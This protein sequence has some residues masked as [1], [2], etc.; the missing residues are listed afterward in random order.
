M[1]SCQTSFDLLKCDNGQIFMSHYNTC[2][3]K[4]W[5]ANLHFAIVAP[6]KCLTLK[7]IFMQAICHKHPFH[8]SWVRASWAELLTET[9]HISP[10]W[11]P[12]C[13]SCG[14][15][16]RSKSEKK[17]WCMS[18]QTSIS[19]NMLD[20]YTY[21]FTHFIYSYEI[22]IL[23]ATSGHCWKWKN[24]V[25]IVTIVIKEQ[26]LSHGMSVMLIWCAYF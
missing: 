21:K 25:H 24:R 15:W 13:H 10:L 9:W 26:N 1:A 5:K 22:F 23:T 2:H 8:V 3:T 20:C 19:W 14:F 16:P 7:D 11:S 17:T 12:R 4:Q 6:K 18:L